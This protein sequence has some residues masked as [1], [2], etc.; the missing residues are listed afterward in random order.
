MGKPI[1]PNETTWKGPLVT[2]KSS[3]FWLVTISLAVGQLFPVPTRIHS[4]VQTILKYARWPLKKNKCGTAS[5]RTYVMSM[6]CALGTLLRRTKSLQISARWNFKDARIEKYRAKH[7][8]MGLSNRVFIEKDG[9]LHFC[10]DHWWLNAL[11]SRGSYSIP[12][13]HDC[14]GFLWK[15]VYFYTFC[16]QRVL[17]SENCRKEYG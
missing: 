1:E 11:I 3:Q 5:F 4:N 7:H 2:L 6:L 8:C 15:Y 17:R 14:T 9:S 10:F 16:K 12:W 13:M